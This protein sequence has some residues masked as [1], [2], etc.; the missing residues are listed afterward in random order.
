MEEDRG[1]DEEMEAAEA[2]Q[3]A[4]S[5]P[6][7]VSEMNELISLLLEDKSIPQDYAEVLLWG[8]ADKENAITYHTKEDIAG[9]IMRLQAA[10]T[11][12]RMTIPPH[13]F[14]FIHALKMENMQAKQKTKLNRSYMGFERKMQATQI[15]QFANLTKNQ[16]QNK[17]IGAKIG[18]GLKALFGG[19]SGG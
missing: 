6:P 5:A 18:G 12:M 4:D 16:N 17:S 1:F 10:L 7:T 3:T 9:Q 13:K 15:R 8:F 2:Q 19:G 14:R 11:W